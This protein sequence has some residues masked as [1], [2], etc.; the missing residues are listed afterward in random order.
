MDG[1][2]QRGLQIAGSGKVAGQGRAWHV[3][4]QRNIGGRGYRVNPY[5]GSCTCPDH[6]ELNIRCKHLWAVLVIMEIET[7]PEGTTVTQTARTTYSNDAHH[8]G[9]AH[10]FTT[11]RSAASRRPPGAAEHVAEGAAALGAARPRWASERQTTV[12][13]SPQWA[14]PLTT[15][16]H[17]V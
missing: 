8:R 15:P 12:T 7:T 5:A 10:G 4:S 3:A 6:Q 17:P 2:Q 14:R 13:T 1:R 16:D 9:R 11:L